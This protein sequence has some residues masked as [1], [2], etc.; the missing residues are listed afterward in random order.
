MY[1]V[2]EDRGK[3]YKVAPGEEILVDRL[4]G[5]RGSLLDF[6]RVLLLSSGP[7][8][9]LVGSPTVE[10]A[11]VKA[12]ILGEAKGTKLVSYKLRRRKNSRTKK[13]H[14]QRYTRLSVTKI[15]PPSS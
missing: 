3:Q 10:G 7:N 12:R 9:T 1:A 13:G 14:R 6:G 2:V 11:C 5:P 8:G 15:I 4:D